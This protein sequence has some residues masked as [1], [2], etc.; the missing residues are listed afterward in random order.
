MMADG[1]EYAREIVRSRLQST[2]DLAK[3]LMAGRKDWKGRDYYLHDIEVMELLPPDSS[4][5]ERNAALLHSTL[6]GGAAI[7]EELLH[8]GVDPEVVE[9]VKLVSNGPNVGGYAA[10]VQK[11]RDVVASGNRSAMKVKLAD[12]LAN[13]GHPTNNYAETIE[14]MR[15]GLRVA[16]GES[17]HSSERYTLS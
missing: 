11:C 4:D 10:Y 9:I 12:M 3:R 2:I 14:I 5:A 7:P 6:D 8:Y 16:L 13:D 17:G 1:D 15:A